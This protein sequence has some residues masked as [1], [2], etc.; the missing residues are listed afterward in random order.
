VPGSRGSRSADRDEPNRVLGFP[1]PAGSRARHDAEPRRDRKA[2]GSATGEKEHGVA[3]DT[4]QQ[5]VLGFP[6]DWF[7]ST[8]QDRG[9]SLARPLQALRLRRSANS[10]QR[11]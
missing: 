6:V 11:P 8:G 3:H 10:E 1:L 9:L 7:R 4:E 5:R 2:E